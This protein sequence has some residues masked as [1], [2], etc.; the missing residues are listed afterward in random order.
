MA[1]TTHEARAV[2]GK[3]GAVVLYVD[4]LAGEYW[5][6]YALSALGAWMNAEPKRLERLLVT[7]IHIP[8]IITFF[9]SCATLSSRDR[10]LE[11]IA[12][13]MERSPLLC[14]ALASSGIFWIS[15]TSQ[16]ETPDATALARRALLHVLSCALQR[17]P[18]AALALSDFQLVPLLLRLAHNWSQV[19]VQQSA[20]QVLQK[21]FS[22]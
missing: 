3:C 18:S 1:H 7:G 19:L 4:L 22:P 16:L 2:L 15:L 20:V 21:I 12:G 6:R 5:S 14:C 10:D 8:K 17:T 13:M 9:Q 11:S